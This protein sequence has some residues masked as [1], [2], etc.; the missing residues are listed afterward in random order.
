MKLFSIE[1]NVVATAYIRADTAEE[2]AELARKHLVDTGIILSSR[3][4]PCGENICIDGRSYE[5]TIKNEEPIALS[6][7]MKIV[8]PYIAPDKE[9]FIIDEVE[10]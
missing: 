5:D 2:A 9:D 4:Q 3:H 1:I 8:G 7:A 6:P 10:L